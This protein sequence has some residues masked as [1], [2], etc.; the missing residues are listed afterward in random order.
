MQLNGLGGPADLEGGVLLLEEAANRG[1]P[2]AQANLGA[3]YQNGVGVPQDLDEALIWFL[4]AQSGG[5]DAVSQMIAD[6]TA[7]MPSSDVTAARLAARERRDAIVLALSSADAGGPEDEA[8]QQALEAV[9]AWLAENLAPSGSFTVG[10]ARE[11]GG[12]GRRGS[13]GSGTTQGRSDISDVAM[14]GCRLEYVNVYTR[15]PLANLAAGGGDTPRQWQFRIDLNLVDLGEFRVQRLQLRNGFTVTGGQAYEVYLRAAGY[16]ANSFATVTP[17]GAPE[18][19]REV[20]I[21]IADRGE[22]DAIAERI[23]E[24]AEL[25][26]AS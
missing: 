6:L 5:F 1:S 23:R 21:P 25:C 9:G 8:S 15:I 26:G 17:D 10:I 19:A 14:T 7:G 22:A 12:L 13:R 3:L 11:S 18:A 20:S 2:M 16:P 4:V 24:A